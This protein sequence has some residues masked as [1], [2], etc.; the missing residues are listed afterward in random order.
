MTKTKAIDPSLVVQIVR[1]DVPHNNLPA[2]E[3]PNL[4]AI[5][6]SSRPAG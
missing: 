2:T 5:V 3:L 4:I 6:Q 1:G